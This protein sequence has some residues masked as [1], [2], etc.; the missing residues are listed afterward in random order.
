M[1]DDYEVGYGHPPKANQFKTGQSGHKSGRPKGSKNLKTVIE[2][3]AYS[4]IHIKEGHKSKS[5]T[6]I[7]ALFK[8]MMNKGI[9][10]NTKAASIALG[11]LEKYLPHPDTEGPNTAPLTEEELS[12]LQNHVELR[13]AI[14]GASDDEDNESE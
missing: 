10:G 3:E 9:Q 13:A 14:D 2:K 1:P 8:S 4:T 6:K 5:V 12:I 11:L 7:E